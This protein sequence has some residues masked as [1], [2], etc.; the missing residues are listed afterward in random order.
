MR[1]S[2]TA[3][4]DRTNTHTHLNGYNSHTRDVRCGRNK[5]EFVCVWIR[6]RGLN[7]WKAQEVFWRFS[8]AQRCFVC[9]ALHNYLLL[10]RTLYT[11]KTLAIAA[12]NVPATLCNTYYTYT[13]V[14]THEVQARVL[15]YGPPHS[16]PRCLLHRSLLRE[17]CTVYTH[18]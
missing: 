11:L 1:S 17:Y 12:Y 15:I 10:N 8:A 6:G 18:T 2:E 9:R 5:Y 7:E 14:Y 3:A 16:S 4:Y 13:H